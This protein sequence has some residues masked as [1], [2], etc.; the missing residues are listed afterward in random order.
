MGSKSSGDS[1]VLFVMNLL[2]SAL[3]ASVVVSVL[4]FAGVMA[5]SWGQ[6]AWA[7]AGLVILTYV[8]VR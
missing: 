2:L 1:R 3:F 4:S 8:V 5:F 6:V 7:T